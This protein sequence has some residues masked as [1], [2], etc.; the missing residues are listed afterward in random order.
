[1]IVFRLLLTRRRNPINTISIKPLLNYTKHGSLVRRKHTPCTTERMN[2]SPNY[3]CICSGSTKLKSPMQQNA[4]VYNSSGDD[5]RKDHDLR[6]VT[7]PMEVRVATPKLIH[8]PQPTVNVETREKAMSPFSMSTIP[9]ID[10]GTEPALSRLGDGD[11]H[12]ETIT[13]AYEDKIAKLHDN[14]QWVSITDRL[15]QF[16]SC[17]FRA[18]IRRLTKLLNET[19]SRRSSQMADLSEIEENIRDM[20]DE[21]P[22]HPQ[23]R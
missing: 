2:R 22:P 21:V 15:M 23:L 19:P 8:I 4:L 9:G 10:E 18:E 7:A 6:L 13:A 5:L 11:E 16:Y 3:R 12:M 14:Y 17:V 20:A 1:M